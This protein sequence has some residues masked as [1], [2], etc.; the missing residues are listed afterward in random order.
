MPKLL[1]AQC[2]RVKAVVV[3]LLYESTASLL[4][5]AAYPFAGSHQPP[6]ASFPNLVLQS[7]LFT[8]IY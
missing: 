2:S 7:D 5:Q 6:I 4:P 3:I 8:L 1:D